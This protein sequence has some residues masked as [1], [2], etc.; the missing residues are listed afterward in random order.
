MAFAPNL[1]RGPLPLQIVRGKV[2]IHAQYGRFMV[3]FGRFYPFF[4]LSHSLIRRGTAAPWGGRRGPRPRK[5]N[6][7]VHKHAQYGRFVANFGRLYPF[8]VVSH[9]SIW[10]GAAAPPEPGDEQ[11]ARGR[12]RV[13]FFYS[14]PRASDACARGGSEL[15]CM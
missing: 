2:H 4:V 8:L 6:G 13:Y 14:L 10:G 12:L 5:W 11:E 9:S 15:A 1:L 3:N 7:K